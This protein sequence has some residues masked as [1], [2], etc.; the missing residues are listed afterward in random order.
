MLA[1]AEYDA[2]VH[3]SYDDV[4]VDNKF[5]P[6]ILTLQ[7]KQSEKDPFYKGIVLTL[8]VINLVIDLGLHNQLFRV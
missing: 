1:Q 3:P 6:S 4:A 2:A 5:N 8:R 7:S